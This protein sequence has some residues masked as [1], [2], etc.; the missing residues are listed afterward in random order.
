MSQEQEQIQYMLCTYSVSG[1]EKSKILRPLSCLGNRH[2]RSTCCTV[3][4]PKK[5]WPAQI[6]SDD[7]AG[8]HGGN[9]LCFGL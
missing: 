9:K 5:I 4:E 2:V 1:T 8:L 6:G 7:G 3:H